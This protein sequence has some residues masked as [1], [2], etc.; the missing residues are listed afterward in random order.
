MLVMMFF[1]WRIYKVAS[2]TTRALNRGYIGSKLPGASCAGSRTSK[3]G[4]FG[5]ASSHSGAGN[6]VGTEVK[7]RVHRGYLAKDDL[8]QADS[9]SSGSG[10]KKLSA[11]SVL[12]STNTRRNRSGPPASHL[13]PPD[14]SLVVNHVDHNR[15]LRCVR[16]VVDFCKLSADRKSLPRTRSEQRIEM[17]P[18]QAP[19]L[20]GADESQ[21]STC[22]RLNTVQAPLL[23]RSSPEDTSRDD[24]TGKEV[25]E[26]DEDDSRSRRAASMVS[27]ASSCMIMIMMSRDDLSNLKDCQAPSNGMSPAGSRKC[28]S[29]SNG[30]AMTLT[31]TNA[32]GSAATT[33]SVNQPRSPSKN[34]FGSWSRNR[35]GGPPP[36]GPGRFQ[37]KRFLAETKAAK[38]VGMIVGGFIFCW[39]PFFTVYL[40]RGFCADKSC[41]PDQLLS[42]FVWLGYAN[43]ALNPLIYGMFSKEFRRAFKNIVCKCK[44]GDDTGVSSLIRQIHLPNLFD[45]DD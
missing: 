7:L 35:A 9:G 8:G 36:S 3:N 10:G 22:D 12:I 14:P 32:S 40:I 5:S 34:P 1:Y 23:T 20:S 26:D 18:L 37:A 43:S 4:G 41:V 25:D 11:R 6:G 15:S 2:E 27:G 17:R 29:P 39:F 16:R 45:E 30:S 19:R 33:T 28:S 44:F 21:L 13:M 24:S 38:T 31:V 42:V